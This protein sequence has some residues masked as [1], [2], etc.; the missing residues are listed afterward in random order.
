MELLEGILTRRS[1][2]QYK[3]DL[4]SEEQVQKLLEAAMSAP[5][6][7]N[8]RPW[9][10]VVIDDRKVLGAIPTMHPHSQMLEEAPLA[11]LVCGDLE[12]AKFE[13]YWIQDCSAATENLLLAAHALGLGAVWLGVYPDEERIAG[14]RRLLALPEHVIPLA[15]VAVGYSEEVKLPVQRYKPERVHSNGW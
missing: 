14:L 12:Q 9:Q 4:V 3:P 11:I 7:G 2:R 6:A 10:F 8:E 15:L 1:I 5:S 13:G